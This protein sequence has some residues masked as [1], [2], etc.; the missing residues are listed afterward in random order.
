V[1]SSLN[2]QTLT[3]LTHIPGI[4]PS[5]ITSNLLFPELNL[6]S[7]KPSL[8]NPVVSNVDVVFSSDNTQSSSLVNTQNSSISESSNSVRFTKFNNPLISYDYKCGHYLGI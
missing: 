5:V 8:T 6:L 1:F 7:T 2:F 4:I 3:S